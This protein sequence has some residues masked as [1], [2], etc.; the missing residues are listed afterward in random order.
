MDSRFILLHRRKWSN[1]RPL[2]P[3]GGGG[4][5]HCHSSLEHHRWPSVQLHVR[6]RQHLCALFTDVG[7]PSLILFIQFSSLPASSCISTL[8]C[9]VRELCPRVLPITFN[10]SL[11]HFCQIFVSA[12][13]S[14]SFT[15]FCCEY[16]CN[17]FFLHSSRILFH[18]HCEKTPWTS[19]QTTLFAA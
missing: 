13:S 2:L 10:T 12:H 17:R 14:C 4:P 9:P 5:R 8:C 3:F 1:L 7:A 18:G 11:S 19:H 6:W 15:W 16:T